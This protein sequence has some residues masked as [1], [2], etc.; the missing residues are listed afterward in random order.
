MLAPSLRLGIV[1]A[2]ASQLPSVAE[3]KQGSDLVCSMLLQRTA[4]EY[5]E[6]AQIHAHLAHARTVYRERRDAMLR[7]LDRHL[8][9]CTWTEPA[10]GLSLWLTLPDGVDERDFI[11]EAADE[12]V[13]VA[14]GQAFMTRGYERASVRLSFGMQP[15]ARIEDGV[16][17]LGRALQ[18]HLGCGDLLVAGQSIGPLV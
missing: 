3:A 15:P 8:P 16:A 18:H 14:P 4:A 11:R 10:G 13:G 2:S 9:G 6:A 1:A 5:L 12:G 17:A 7:A